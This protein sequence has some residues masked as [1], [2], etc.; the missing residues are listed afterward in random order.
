MAEHRQRVDK[1]V[2]RDII[3]RVINPLLL[4]LGARYLVRPYLGRYDDEEKTLNWGLGHKNHGDKR[5]R[6]AVVFQGITYRDGV[7]DTG[8]TRKI[9]VNRRILWTVKHDNR[10]AQ[11]DETRGIKEL[12]FDESYNEVKT[13]FSIDIVTNFSAAAQGTIAGIGGNISQ[14]INTH[15]HAG[16]STFQYNKKKTERVIDTSTR[17]RYP[18]PVF[19]DTYDKLGRVSGRK[20]V[21]EGPIWLI[22][23]P[24]ATVHTITPITQWGIWDARIKLNVYDWAGNYGLLP[25]G[26][27]KNELEFSSFNELIDFMEGDLVLQ[28][29]WT[30]GL[31]KKLSKASKEGLAWLKDEENRNVGPVEWEQIRV[32]DNVSALEPRVITED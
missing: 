15:T 3:N 19:I 6:S 26:K 31:K 1:R 5:H 23:C 29:P 30:A 22:D 24:V 20:M 12:V 2:S 14:S 13:D 18:G 4:D 32:N 10:L 16:E 9:E 25:K 28:Y 8:R 17:L 27:N 11:N 7:K 21:E